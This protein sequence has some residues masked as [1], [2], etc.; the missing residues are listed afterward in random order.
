MK[1]VK[2]AE[3]LIFLRKERKLTQ[4]KLAQELNYS[5]K[6]ISK[7]ENG[8]ALPDVHTLN[9]LSRYFHVSMDTLYNGDIQKDRKDKEKTMREKLWSRLIISVLAVCIVWFVAVVAY[10]CVKLVEQ[11]S[12]WMAF[13]YAV[14]VSLIV[15][16]VFN[17][18]WGKTRLNYLIISLLIWTVLTTIHLQLLQV[19]NVWPIYFIG[20]PLQIATVLW[21]L[22]FRKVIFKPKKEENQ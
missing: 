13:I 8:D 21:S 2:F 18:I 14:P 6:T 3:N 12:F 4:G 19:L 11:Q 20:I 16:L 15:L 1:D 5:D 10:V 7:W 9:A 17:S 22:L